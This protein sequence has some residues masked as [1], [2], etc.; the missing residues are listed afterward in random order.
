MA[1]ELIKVP[2]VPHTSG[3]PWTIL[4]LQK[5]G[6]SLALS[7]MTKWERS[8]KAEFKKIKRVLTYAA[9]QEKII[10]PN[11]AKEGEGHPGT[12][13]ARAHHG[14]AR[15]MFFYYPE[16]KVIVCT[17]T[18]WKGSGIQNTAFQ[19]CAALRAAY[20]NSLECHE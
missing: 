1:F 13:E 12:W 19:H 11:H 18:Y 8:E 14:K 15:V 3:N 20:F 17:N 2:F 16:R 7:E 10:N 4:A 9:Q 5:D 6:K